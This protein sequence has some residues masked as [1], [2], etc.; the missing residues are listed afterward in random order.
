MRTKSC[1]TTAPFFYEKQQP[2]FRFEDRILESSTFS[3]EQKLLHKVI[4]L[5]PFPEAVGSFPL[6]VKFKITQ[7]T[8]SHHLTV[9]PMSPNPGRQL[10]ALPEWNLKADPQHHEVICLAD[11][12]SLEDSDTTTTNR[13][14]PGVT[15][16][17][18]RPVPGK[19]V[20][21]VQLRGAPSVSRWLPR[22]FTNNWIK[23][24]NVKSLLS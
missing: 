4:L 1:V 2:Q 15:S 12:A 20:H 10:S 13:Y 21:V 17:L 3:E 24:R 9:S 11:R 7:Q 22:R 5:V 23:P 14:W 6:S 8:L 16:L 18:P 19:V